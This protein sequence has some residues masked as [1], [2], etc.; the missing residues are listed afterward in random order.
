MQSQSIAANKCISVGVPL[1]FVPRQL[2]ETLS[3][4]STMQYESID[5]YLIQEFPELST[6]KALLDSE[7]ENE[8]PGQYLLFEDIFRT[9]VLYILVAEESDKRDRKLKQ[10]FEFT[11]K[12]LAAGGD[13]EN[14]A[15]ISILESQSEAWLKAA[16]PFLG[17]L[18]ESH[19]D[20]DEPEW[21]Q[22]SCL[23]G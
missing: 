8:K 19:L 13:L 17:S 9:Y 1:R 23:V 12:L 15:F 2:C 11:E 6:A 22:L 18:A 4:A 14:L 16:K 5:E 21:R 20:E 3:G 10:I 7:W